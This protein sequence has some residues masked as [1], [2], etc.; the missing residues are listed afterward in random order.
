MRYACLSILTGQAVTYTV[1][2][3]NAGL[4]WQTKLEDPERPHF[5]KDK[6]KAID[7]KFFLV[8]L[9][10]LV[11]LF[12][13]MG[14]LVVTSQVR[15]EYAHYEEMTVDMAQRYSDMLAYSSDAQ[16]VVTGLLEEKLTV[17][18]QAVQQ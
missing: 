14:T 8:P 1:H 16:I 3:S 12:L 17:A 5:M 18:L 15:D 13:V 4:S 11:F 2:V 10:I 6:L 9:L 7:I